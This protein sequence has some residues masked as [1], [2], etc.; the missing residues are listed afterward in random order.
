MRKIHTRFPIFGLLSII[1]VVNAA[2]LSAQS[3]LTVAEGSSSAASVNFKTNLCEVA[4]QCAYTF[5]LFDS[6]GDGWNG[7]SITVQQNGVTVATVG[8][9]DYEYAST[10]TV[11]LCDNQNTVLIWNSGSSDSECSFEVLDP[12]GNVIYTMQSIVFSDNFDSYTA[13]SQLAQSNAAWTTWSSA[14]GTAEDGVI[15]NAQS[16]SAP[17]SL[18]VSGSVDQVFPFGNYTSGLYTVSFN[19]YIPSTGNGGYFNIQHILKAQ[20]ALEC[21][22]YSTGG[23]YLNVGGSEYNFSCPADA[24]FPIT[25]DVDMD[26]DQA[27]L[28]INNVTVHTWPFSYQSG[29]TNGTNQLAG[30]NFYAGS[31]ISNSTSGTYY[32]DDFVVTEVSAAQVGQFSVDAESIT[33]SLNPNLTAS[34]SFTMSNPGTGSTDFN[35]IVTYDIPNPDPTS[36][37]VLDQH[38]YQ[39][40]PYTFVGWNGEAAD[41]DFAIG[42]PS[43][44]LQQHIGKTL[45]EI[46]FYMNQVLPT[47]KVRVYGMNNSTLNPGPGAVL[48]E[49]TFTPESGWNYIQL[50]T[51]FLIDG[52]DLWFGVWFVQPEGAYLAPLDGYAANDYSC[53]YK[54]GSTWYSHFSNSSYDFNLCLGGKIDGTPITPWLTVSPASGS[55][56]AGTTVTEAVTANTNGMAVGETK[57]AKL[58]CFSTDLENSEVIVPVSLTV[59]DVADGSWSSL[60]QQGNVAY[61]TTRTLSDTL[62][63]FISDCSGSTPVFTDPTIATENATNVTLTTAT[64]NATITNPD[65][66]TITAKGFEWKATAGGT[67]TQIA[68]I[69]T[70]NNFSANLSGLTPY[71]NYTYRAFITYNG[72]SVYGN[73]VSFTTVCDSIS[74]VPSNPIT[75]GTGTSTSYT[76]PFNNFYRN[77][78][79]EMIYP[80]SLIDESGL[81]TSIAFHVSDVPSSNYP[82]N[83]LTI[84]MGTSSDSVHTSNSSWLPMSDLTEVFSDMNVSSPTDTGWLTIELDT[85]FQYNGTE[86][87]VIVA[88]KTMPTY[89]SALKFHYTTGPSGCSL[90]RQNDSDASYANHPGSST[91]STSTIRPNLQLTFVPV[92]GEYCYSVKNLSATDV[93]TTDANIIWQS[94]ESAIS[95]I[96]QYKT[97]DQP[98][99]ENVT[100]VNTTDTT[101][102]LNG[103]TAVT[104]YNVRV[105]SYCGSDTSAWKSVSFTTPCEESWD[106]LP[107]MEDF[108]GYA[109]YSVPNC[110]T[111]LQTYTNGSTVYPYVNNASANA[112]NGTGFFYCYGGNNFFALP[113]FSESVNNLRLTFW[114]KPGGTTSSYGYVEVGVMSGL[115]DAN[116]FQQVAAFYADSIGSDAWQKYMVD[117]SDVTTSD[118][119]YIVIR[120]YVSSTYAW[121]FDDMMV[122]YIPSCEAPT[123]L[124]FVGATPNSVSLSWNPGEASVFNVYYKAVGDEEYSEVSGVT[125]DASGSYTLMDLEPATNYTI[126]VI[127]VCSDGSETPGDP[128]AVATTMIPVGLPYTTDFSENADRNW[129]LNNGTCINYWTMGA[130]ADTANALFITNDG[131]SPAYTIASAISMVSASKLFTIGTA[132]QVNISFDVMV[133][134]ESSYDYIKLFLAPETELYPAKAGTVPTSSEYG[135]NSYSTYAFDFSD[136]M[137]YSTSS[138][139]IAYKFNLTDGNLVHIDALIPNP[140]GNPNENST[141]Q[142]VF[143][144][145]NDGGGGTQP[146]AIISNEI[147]RASCRERV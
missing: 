12:N 31:P 134:G 21:Y 122:D 5:N 40:D 113:H 84:Y 144:W 123:E 138:S 58:H 14:P 26:N 50:T 38:Y 61:A 67:Y 82:F 43:S 70:D 145:K 25:F 69:G 49:Q 72:Y 99:D 22:F 90:Y 133:G 80:A 142:V 117:F 137:G 73:E 71:T 9:T 42:Y 91:G 57:T 118:N 95:Y 23:G 135:Y 102:Y 106:V 119:D 94:S 83:T 81:I 45:N 120:R 56:S 6:S 20:W 96:L 116:T 121:Y 46:Y 47:A 129:L 107:Y 111:R 52:S 147:G 65:D 130:V 15:S 3:T 32:V 55:I 76:L 93:T 141:A 18:L 140:H 114:M 66:V 59:N 75:I 35:V 112:H 85:P 139:N 41:V 30:I 101:Y 28:T 64:L 126:Y 74:M 136:Y 89:T 7:A 16:A 48:Y 132:P 98:W 13:G 103:L 110:W 79:S 53:W 63:T 60:Y 24:W 100:T 27:S 92:C 108:E 143:A 1:L 51:P 34:Q 44:A 104:T 77:S 87:L 37:G 11:M 62:T 54:R 29:N 124:A 115:N 2:P 127:S 4:D 78:W 146:G 68:G 10:K 125:L 128:I 33:F 36:T 88:S 109:T 86:N 8:F 97:A 17:N 131:T 105:A 39:A 19:M